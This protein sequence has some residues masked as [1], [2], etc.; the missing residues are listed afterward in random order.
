MSNVR[1]RNLLFIIGVLL[2]TNIGMLVYFTWMKKP[3]KDHFDG[4]NGRHGGMYDFLKT[5][6]GFDSVQLAAFDTLKKQQRGGL[7]PYFEELNKSKD[8]L[9][10]LVGNPNDS[11]VRSALVIIGKKQQA[12]ELQFFENFRSIRN[13]CTESQRVKFDSLAPNAIRRLMSPQ[14]RPNMGQQKKDTA[15]AGN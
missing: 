5:E 6:I 11:A 2:V 14:R 15:K 4:N 8:S 12:L 3:D 13:I 7:R 1:N 9:Y 10:Q